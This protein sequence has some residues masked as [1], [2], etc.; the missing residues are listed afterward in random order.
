MERL[1]IR[2]LAA[3]LGVTPNSLYS[4]VR[5]KDEL[6]RGAF[7]LAFGNLEIPIRRGGT[8][9]D[10]LVELSTWLRRRLLKHPNLVTPRFVEGAPFPFTSFVTEVG[11]VL[12]EAGLEEKALIENVY[13]VFYHTVGFVMMEVSR[14]KYGLPHLPDAAL[15]DQVDTAKFEDQERAAEQTAGLVRL[16]RNLDLDSVFAQSLRA[17][18][19]G[20]DV[21]ARPTARRRG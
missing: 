12:Y 15:V 14:R 5:D 6:I 11:L 3:E 13:V 9:Q 7:D 2:Q 10:R 20:L 16:I 19:S 4:Y 21:D 8:W 17:V 18:I 1:G